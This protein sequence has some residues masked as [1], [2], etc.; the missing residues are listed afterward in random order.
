MHCHIMVAEG[1]VYIR[2]ELSSVSL[3]YTTFSII[4]IACLLYHTNVYELKV[5]AYYL[6]HNSSPSPPN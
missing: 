2:T 3:Y 1:D 5:H 6:H 4:M